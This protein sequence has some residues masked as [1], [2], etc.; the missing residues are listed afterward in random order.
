MKSD[1]SI[2]QD[3]NDE[4]LWEPAVDAAGVGV[5]VDHGVVTLTG[6]VHSYLGDAL[7]RTGLALPV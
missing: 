1:L 2:K 7:G 4:L 6:H 5:E 3:V